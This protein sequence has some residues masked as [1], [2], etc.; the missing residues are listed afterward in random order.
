[1][2][3]A[4]RGDGV[5]ATAVAFRALV[6]RLDVLSTAERTLLREWLDRVVGSAGG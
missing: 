1:M 3:G 5:V 6:P 2:T 4:D